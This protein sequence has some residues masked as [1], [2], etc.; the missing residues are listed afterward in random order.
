MKDSQTTNIIGFKPKEKTDYVKIARNGERFWLEKLP[1]GMSDTKYGKVAS[2][3]V[4]VHPYKL[5]DVIE[6]KQD[7]VLYEQ[8]F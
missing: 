5:G 3:L 7:E 1:D 8:R 2:H 4:E 6:F